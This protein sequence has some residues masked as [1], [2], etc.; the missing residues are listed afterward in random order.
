M[1]QAKEYV[2]PRKLLDEVESLLAMS[3]SKRYA[4]LVDSKVLH[5]PLKYRILD[6]LF[7]AWKLFHL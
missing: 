4:A 7:K 1:T 6:E 3:P 2:S 5:M